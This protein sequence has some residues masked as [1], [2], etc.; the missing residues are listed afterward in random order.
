MGGFQRGELISLMLNEKELEADLLKNLKI[1]EK[2]TRR[3]DFFHYWIKDLELSEKFIIQRHGLTFNDF[4]NNFEG[5]FLAHRK[6]SK[7]YYKTKYEVEKDKTVFGKFDNIER[8]EKKKQCDKCSV[9]GG[10]TLLC[11]KTNEWVCPTCCAKCKGCYKTSANWECKNCELKNMENGKCSRMKR[12]SLNYSGC[13]EYKSVT[14][15]REME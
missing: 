5:F 14:P 15:Y 6:N 4:I 2:D 7:H 8:I 12:V 9:T 3:K 1:F 11:M 13:P 10:R